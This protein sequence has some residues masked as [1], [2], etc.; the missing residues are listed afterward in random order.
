MKTWTTSLLRP[1]KRTSPKCVA[2]LIEKGANV[3]ATD[4][5]GNPALW[6]ACDVFGEANRKKDWDGATIAA[7]SMVTLAINDPQVGVSFEDM[8][9]IATSHGLA[10]LLQE[11]LDLGV[12]AN[13]SVPGSS[14][15]LIHVTGKGYLDCVNVL[16]EAGANVNAESDSNGMSALA[17]AASMERP[18]CL[19]RLLE[20][21]ADVNKVTPKGETALMLA[22]R[23][24]RSFN[25][26]RHLS[27]KLQR[28]FTQMTPPSTADVG[29][30]VKILID[31]GADVNMKDKDGQT[32]LMFAAR[33]G[34]L[35]RL[36]LL[37]DTGASVNEVDKNSKTAIMVATEEGHAECVKRLVEEGAR[38]NKNPDENSCKTAV[39]FAAGGGHYACLDMLIKAGADVNTLDNDNKTALMYAARSGRK[40]CVT[41]LLQT[42]ADVNNRDVNG[43]TA[44]MYAAVAGSPDCVD[45]LLQQKVGVNEKDRKGHDGSGSQCGLREPRGYGDTDS[46]R[47]HCQPQPGRQPDNPDVCSHEW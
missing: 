37:L 2:T 34:C 23:R 14:T 19:Q 17:T 47:S 33:V 41:P 12:N 15:A 4:D 3:N 7:E 27:D 46:S 5:E 38:L 10:Q 30:C 45:I 44:L 6:Y 20:A 1:Q 24:D 21:G 16:L 35:T 22:A 8:L 13:H 28:W 11:L 43:K 26:V 25:P 42:G 18:G 32:A 36:S 9:V 39:M 40:E 29:I 31:A